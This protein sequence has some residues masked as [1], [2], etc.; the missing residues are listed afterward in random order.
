LSKAISKAPSSKL[1]I[2][3]E[4]GGVI[5]S[6][7]N[8]YLVNPSLSDLDVLLLSTYMV[9][10]SQKGAGA[11]YDDV[12]SM[13]VTL[14]RR[15]D[16]FRKVMHI[17]RPRYL[18]S[19]GTKLYFRAEGLEL[20]RK[21]LGQVGK[22]PVY[23]IKSG[24]QFTGIKLLEQF[25]TNEIKG[26]ELL[27]C[28]PYVS[29]VT[30]FPFTAISGRVKIMKILTSNITEPEKFVNYAAKMTR[31]MGIQVQTKISKKIH[32]RYLISNE[33]CWAIGTSIKDVGNKDT[34]IRDISDVLT[35][36]LDLFQERWAE[37]EAL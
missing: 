32:D 28:D 3:E 6:H 30:L 16:N 10:F 37:S 33:T 31:E 8:R 27:V 4:V 9:E 5:Q 12:K 18:D 35:S 34:T 15:E 21:K 26:D 36:M 20:L 25:L 24:Q 14:S 13:F 23:V 19:E 29:H 17:A 1:V 11:E 7:Y 2:P 22:S